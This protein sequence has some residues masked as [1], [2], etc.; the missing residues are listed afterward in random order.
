VDYASAKVRELRHNATRAREFFDAVLAA[1]RPP[2]GMEEEEGLTSLTSLTNLGLEEETGTA[3]KAATA[4][5][6]AATA[7]AKS[8]AGEV[9]F[10]SEGAR[11]GPSFVEDLTAFMPLPAILPSD[12]EDLEVPSDP[13]LLSGA[14]MPTGGNEGENAE[15][16]GGEGK[17]TAGGG[18]SGD[19]GAFVGPTLPPSLRPSLPFG[20]GKRLTFLT[21]YA[22]EMQQGLDQRLQLLLPSTCACAAT[23]DAT[24]AKDSESEERPRRKGAHISAARALL[25]KLRGVTQQPKQEVAQ[26]K[27]SRGGADSGKP[28]PD[29]CPLVWL[30]DHLRH[31][32]DAVAQLTDE[33][34]ATPPLAAAAAAAPT[35]TTTATP[36]GGTSASAALA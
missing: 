29:L 17:E 35:T 3:A 18:A 14:A 2:L 32:V 11:F 1:G 31:L 33:P 6:T 4:A 30:V 5:K 10:D 21:H 22:E 36:V 24:A 34:A 16:V 23:T 9:T 26:A 20:L 19:A 7:K 15:K 12:L 13:L 28:C 8:T 27:K 25:L